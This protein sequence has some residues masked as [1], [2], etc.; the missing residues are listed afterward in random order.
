MNECNPERLVPAKLYYTVILI[1]IRNDKNPRIATN[2][3]IIFK[4]DV[5]LANNSIADLR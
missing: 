2:Y 5:N 4:A 1:A 3:F